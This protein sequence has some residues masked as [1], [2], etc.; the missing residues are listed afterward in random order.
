MIAEM[1]QNTLLVD[2]CPPFRVFFMKI[3][4]YIYPAV[5]RMML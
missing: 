4:Y 5:M 1:S 3:V 2:I